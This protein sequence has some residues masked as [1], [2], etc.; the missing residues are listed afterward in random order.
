MNENVKRGLQRLRSALAEPV[1][2][3]GATA[4]VLQWPY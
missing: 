1:N 3:L 2:A 4:G